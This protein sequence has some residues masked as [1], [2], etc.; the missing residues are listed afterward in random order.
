MVTGREGQIPGIRSPWRPPNR[1]VNVDTFSSF[2]VTEQAV[3]IK[4]ICYR[5][6][7]TQ[8]SNDCS[9][10]KE[11]PMTDRDHLAGVPEHTA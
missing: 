5:R 6:S 3:E 4:S 7:S 11:T 8:I 9:N 2:S 1:N 10:R